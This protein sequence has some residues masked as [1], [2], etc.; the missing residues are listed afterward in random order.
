MTSHFID[1]KG[2]VIHYVSGEYYVAGWPKKKYNSLSDAK[3]FID[4]QDPSEN[5]VNAKTRSK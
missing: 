1:Y 5:Y 2:F 3:A 4:R